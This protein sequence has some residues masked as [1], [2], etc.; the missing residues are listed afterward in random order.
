MAYWEIPRQWEGR[1]AVVMASGQSLTKEDAEAVRHLPRV[2]TNGTY[3]MAPDA[4]V[5]FGADVNFWRNEG[6]QDVYDCPGFKVS[7][8]L[9]GGVHPNTPESVLIVRVGGRSGLEAGQ[10]HIRTG[11]NSGHA[12]IHIAA[13][14]GAKR[15]ILLGLD[16]TGGHWHGKH[17]KGLA[18]PT[19]GAFKRWKQHFTHLAK[20]LQERDIEI[21]NCSPISVL[22]CFPKRRLSDCL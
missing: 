10:T 15:I 21:F 9:A 3:R 2:V 11:G 20:A 1:T 13:S 17:P 12:A 16:M 14:M 19:E 22:Q 8:D 18:N 4:E 5:I 6:Y 7:L